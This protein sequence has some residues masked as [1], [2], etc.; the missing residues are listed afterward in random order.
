LYQFFFIQDIFYFFFAACGFFQ[1]KK[2]FLALKGV[3]SA[4]LRVIIGLGDVMLGNL[5]GLR[6]VKP[7]KN[8][9]LDPAFCCQTAFIDFSSIS[10]LPLRVRR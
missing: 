10:R 1:K 7:L 2:K 8:R 9:S 6:A 3:S 5:L 4:T